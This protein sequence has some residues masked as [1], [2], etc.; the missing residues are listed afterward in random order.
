MSHI[1]NPHSYCILTLHKFYEVSE[2]W[3]EIRLLVAGTLP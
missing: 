3:P 2:N 1:K